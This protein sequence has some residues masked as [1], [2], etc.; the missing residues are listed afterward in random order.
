MSYLYLDIS[1]YQGMPGIVKPCFLYIV[2]YSNTPTLHILILQEKPT[3]PILSSALK[4]SLSITSK[5]I[6]LAKISPPGTWMEEKYCDDQW[7]KTLDKKLGNIKIKIKS[8]RSYIKG[9][10]ARFLRELRVK[11]SS[12]GLC[13]LE[14][15]FVTHANPINIIMNCKQKSKL[16]R[17]KLNLNLNL[18]SRIKM[19]N[20]KRLLPDFHIRIALVAETNARSIRITQVLV[21]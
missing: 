7:R 10:L 12:D 8:Q 2:L 4:V 14:I 20:L 15:L 21:L 11:L 6:F 18:N 5:K 19:Q 16:P 13:L 1:I 17:T 3:S 9:E